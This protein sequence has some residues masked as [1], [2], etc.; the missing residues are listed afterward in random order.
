M[1]QGRT[2]TVRCPPIRTGIV[3]LT[4]GLGRIC[5]ILATVA[6][7]AAATG[8]RGDSPTGAAVRATGEQRQDAA[9]GWLRLERQ[10]SQARAA[11]SPRTA[12]ESRAIGT[13]ERDERLRYRDLLD[14]QQAEMAGERRGARRESDLNGGLSSPAAGARLQ[15]RLMDQR[16]QQEALRLRMGTERRLVPRP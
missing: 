4:Q 2:H 16:R 7:V 3:H 10:Q 12:A 1:Y 15:G 6:A 9:A 11:A 8:A 5:I 14:R 13:V